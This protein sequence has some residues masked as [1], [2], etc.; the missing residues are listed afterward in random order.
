[1]KLLPRSDR[2][3]QGKVRNRRVGHRAGVSSRLGAGGLSGVNYFSGKSNCRSSPGRPSSRSPV[4]SCAA[5]RTA[6]LRVGARVHVP[7][8]R[9]H[10][11][12]GRAYQPCD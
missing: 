10:A 12:V 11:R 2:I 4:N 5:G 7:T 6:P 8:R 9:S 3:R 1:M